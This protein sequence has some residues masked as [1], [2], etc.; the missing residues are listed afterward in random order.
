MAIKLVKGEHWAELYWEKHLEG[1]LKKE[2]EK[3]LD[4]LEKENMRIIEQVYNFM[5]DDSEIQKW[6]QKIKEHKWVKVIER[7]SIL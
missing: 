6:I 1:S 5:R 7:G 2:E 4:R 3:E